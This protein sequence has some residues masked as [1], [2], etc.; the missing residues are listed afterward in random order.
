M[1]LV[2]ARVEPAVQ[3]L[4]STLQKFGP[5][6]RSRMT[7]W[8][9]VKQYLLPLRSLPTRYA[10]LPVSSW[11]IL[12]TNLWLEARHVDALSI[13]SRIGC[14]AVSAYLAATT[15][16]FHLME[17]GREIRDVVCYKDNGKW[18]FHA[19]GTAQPFEALALYEERRIQSRLTPELVGAYL[20]AVTGLRFPLVWAEAVQGGVGV[21]RSTRDVKVEIL[22][23]SVEENA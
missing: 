9:E 4:E 20:Q 23:Y 21:E 17:S 2:E 10:L 6:Q 18:V 8:A 15:R 11:T 16:H 13:S 3:A 1:A 12:L 22:T 19:T 7:G 14:R 5:T